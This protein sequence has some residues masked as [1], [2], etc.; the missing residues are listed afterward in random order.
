MSAKLNWTESVLPTQ[1]N[2]SIVNSFSLST[3]LNS[4]CTIKKKKKMKLDKC[5]KLKII[6]KKFQYGRNRLTNF[7]RFAKYV[8]RRP[9][10]ISVAS[11]EATRHVLNCIFNLH[12]FGTQNKFLDNIENYFRC[13]IKQTRTLDSFSDRIGSNWW[14]E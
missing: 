12:H 3:Q 11:L 1:N 4:L 10:I 9:N 13:A 2:F 8:Q 6:I 7:L 14:V 5:W